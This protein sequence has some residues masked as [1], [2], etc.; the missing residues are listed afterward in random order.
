[1]ADGIYAKHDRTIEHTF[2][3]TSYTRQKCPRCETTYELLALGADAR[4][5]TVVCQYCAHPENF[6]QVEEK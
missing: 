3:N 1:M 4:R 6:T 5:N 2:M